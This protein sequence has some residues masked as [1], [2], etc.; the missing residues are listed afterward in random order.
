MPFQQWQIVLMLYRRSSFAQ[1]ERKLREC[2]FE[3]CFVQCVS[4]VNE[5]LPPIQY[6]EQAWPVMKNIAQ[7]AEPHHKNVIPLWDMIKHC[8]DKLKDEISNPNHRNSSSNTSSSNGRSKSNVSLPN[9]LE[10]SK[11]ETEVTSPGMVNFSDLSQGLYESFN[12]QALQEVA[13]AYDSE[14]AA[15]EAK[16][17]P[18]VEV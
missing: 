4:K 1:S 14:E 15:Q 13:Y 10:E 5:N 3:I 17:P 11:V 12:N 9:F 7:A 2:V 18:T 16:E 6:Y 8:I